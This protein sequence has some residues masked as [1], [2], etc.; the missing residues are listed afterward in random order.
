MILPTVTTIAPDWRNKLAEV[1]K[2]G[3]REINLFLTCL[4]K[5]QRKETYE[6]LKKIKVARIPFVHLRSDMEP[7]EL[8]YLAKEYKTEVYNIHTSREYPLKFDYGKRKKKIYI[9][10]TFNPYDEE[11]I[12]EFGGVCLDFAHLENARVFKPETYRQNIEIIEKYKCGCNHISPEVKFSL[13][14]KELRLGKKHPH[15]MENLSQFD[16]LKKYPKRYFSRHIAMEV[17]NS[18]EEQLEAI[19]Y[20]KSILPYVR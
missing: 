12:K 19:K 17:E 1:D 10:N 2:L 6:L 14:E 9:E 13:F 3:L 15:V 16:Y 11:E 5:E 18:I 7:W 20:I 4:N 8:D